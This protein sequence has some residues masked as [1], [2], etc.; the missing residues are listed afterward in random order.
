MPKTRFLLS[1]LLVAAIPIT[2]CGESPPEG[3]GATDGTG[4]TGGTRATGGEGPRGPGQDEWTPVAKDRVAAECGLDPDRLAQADV[5]IDRGYAVI[6]HGKLCHEY[7]PASLYPNGVDRPE[8]VFS[9][10]KTLAGLLTGA[11]AHRTRDFE[12][13]GPKTGPLRD[14]DRV[15][16]WLD[17]FSFNPD[18][19]VAHVLAMVGHNDDLTSAELD[20]T[21]DTIGSDQINRLND[22][23]AAAIEQDP[24]LGA[25]VHEFWERS[26]LEPL[27]MTQSVWDGNSPDKTYALGWTTTVRDMARVGLMMLDGG[28][29]NDERLVGEDWIYKMTHPSFEIATTGYGYLTRLIARSNI[30]N[31]SSRSTEPNAECTPSAIWDEYPHGLSESPDCN[32]IAPWDCSQ[33]HD[34]GVWYADGAMGNYIIGHRGLDM[35]L[36]VKNIGVDISQDRVWEAVRPALVALDPMFAGDEEAFCDAYAAGDYAPN[37]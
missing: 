15:D 25:N 4:A 35:V 10:T 8:F 17:S 22:V 3:T 34:V 26:L 13:T 37:L 1:A 5:E 6:R 29:W 11:A 24:A 28:L 19:Q 30:D 2:G 36:V 7:Y 23:V 32:Y 14:T 33:A 31:G 21:Y 27:G 12:R 18:A 9:A 16:Y 20:F